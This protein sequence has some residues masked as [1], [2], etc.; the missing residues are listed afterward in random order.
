M[1]DA[2]YC[3]DIIETCQLIIISLRNCNSG[4][5]SKLM[6]R[7]LNGFTTCPWVDLIIILL[8]IVLK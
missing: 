5:K 6:A 4:K 2:I 8:D 7:S 1:A 3:I